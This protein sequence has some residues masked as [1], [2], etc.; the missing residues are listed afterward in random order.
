MIEALIITLREGLE[1]ALVLGLILVY[2]KKVGRANLRKFAYIGLVLAIIASGIGAYTFQTLSLG[3]EVID[4]IEAYV[5]LTAAFFVGTMV[6][7]MFKT[8]KNFKRQVEQ[9]VDTITRK[10]STIAQR[11]GLILLAF[12]MVFREGA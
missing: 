8:A 12:T 3:E 9:R 11:S 4:T 1:A 10:K 6:V 5:M 2:L 7:W